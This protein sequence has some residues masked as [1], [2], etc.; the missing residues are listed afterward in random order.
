MIAP[1]LAER[2]TVGVIDGRGTGC[3]DRPE[4]K[5]SYVPDEVVA[6]LTAVLDA[7]A[8]TVRLRTRS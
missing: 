1:S 2:F 7:A 4:T 3:S 6:D 8:W 5:Q